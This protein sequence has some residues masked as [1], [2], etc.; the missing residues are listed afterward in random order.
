[1][2]RKVL[3]SPS[4][5][6]REMWSP[7]L[8]VARS[9]LQTLAPAVAGR[10]GLRRGRSRPASSVVIARV[11]PSGFGAS[12]L[13]SARRPLH[14]RPL[15]GRED[16][17]PGDS[18][19][20]PSHSVVEKV[21]KS[22]AVPRRASRGRRSRRR[23]PPSAALRGCRSSPGLGLEA[24]DGVDAW[25]CLGRP[26]VVLVGGRAARLRSLDCAARLGGLAE[27]DDRGRAGA[28]S[29]PTRSA[30]AGPFGV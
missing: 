20:V 15:L 11:S 26:G 8:G 9:A 14:R 25:H 5:L 17:A 3:V 16:R 7:R 30:A 21:S 22:A 23:S 4:R 27:G 10:V 6:R 13:K 18:G 29:A 12:Q 1:M 24:G 19:S 28:S 2:C